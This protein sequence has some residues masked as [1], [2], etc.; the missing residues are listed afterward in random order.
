[1]TRGS[2]CS[3]NLFAD[4]ADDDGSIVPYSVVSKER[5]EERANKD[6]LNERMLRASLCKLFIVLASGSSFVDHRSIS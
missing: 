5:S 2:F 4:D 1:M 3:L 6:R